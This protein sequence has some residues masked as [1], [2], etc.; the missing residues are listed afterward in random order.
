MCLAL[1]LDSLVGDRRLLAGKGESNDLWL[2]FYENVGAVT[3]TE[4]F[5]SSVSTQSTC[6]LS[7]DNRHNREGNTQALLWVIL[8]YVNYCSGSLSTFRFSTFSLFVLAE[9]SHRESR[10]VY[11]PRT[12]SVE[13]ALSTVEFGN[14]TQEGVRAYTGPR[15]QVQQASQWP[16]HA[17][18][19][20]RRL[21][22]TPASDD[23]H[24]A[25]PQPAQSLLK[26]ACTI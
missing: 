20:H 18:S 12:V 14:P 11:F 6:Q 2:M 3:E 8:I 22:T 1:R 21:G 13:T 9:L 7:L 5:L 17:Y 24:S 15:R 10:T 25:I 23:G 16:C 4:P 19:W 26:H